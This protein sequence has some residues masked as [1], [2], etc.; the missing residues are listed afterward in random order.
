MGVGARVDNLGVP[1]GSAVRAVGQ[2]APLLGYLALPAPTNTESKALPPS[3]ALPA[4]V[5]TEGVESI[6]GPPSLTGHP[7]TA[8]PSER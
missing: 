3:M 6:G 4:N 2:V 7:G 5:A 1:Q 8:E